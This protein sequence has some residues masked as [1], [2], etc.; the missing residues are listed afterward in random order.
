MCWPIVVIIARVR[1]LKSLGATSQLLG[2]VVH[3]IIASIGASFG[4]CLVE[5][6]AG[7]AADD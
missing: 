3:V 2:I 6:G 5:A 4:A 1:L 7:A